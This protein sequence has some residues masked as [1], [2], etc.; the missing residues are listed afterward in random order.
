MVIAVEESTRERAKRLWAES[1]AWGDDAQVEALVI[2]IGEQIRWQG[3]SD[4][5]VRLVAMQMEALGLAGIPY[6]HTRTYRAWREAGRQV[7]KGEKS[8]L[9]SI[10]WIE[11]RSSEGEGEEGGGRL[12]P[13][14]T[15]LFHFDQTDPIGEG[16]PDVVPP[17]APPAERSAEDGAKP[18]AERRARKPRGKTAGLALIQEG[19]EVTIN[20][21][22]CG[23]EVRFAEKPSGEIIQG[24]KDR[25]FRWGRT[26]GC[27][28]APRREDTE[29]F[30]YSLQLN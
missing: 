28:Y 27:W 6:I 15:N 2:T 21:E 16:D 8:Q 1:K 26:A 24:L 13:K 23:V 5:N 19:I 12:Y 25:G 22:K 18:R 30:A 4:R 29:A 3:M 11:G 9:F 20:K 17:V 14:T 10:T 7:R